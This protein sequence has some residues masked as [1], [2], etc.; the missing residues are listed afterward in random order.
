MRKR[1]PLFEPWD[2]RHQTR[3]TLSEM[4]GVLLVGFGLLAILYVIGLM[5]A[6]AF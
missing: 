1:N 3:P 4:A 5:A 2:Q 6:I